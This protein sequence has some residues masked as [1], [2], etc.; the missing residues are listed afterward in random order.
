MTGK[1]HMALGVLTTLFITQ[2]ESP[3]EFLICL[4]VSSMGSVL[5]DIDVSTSSSRNVLNKTLLVIGISIAILFFA[6][7]KWGISLSEGIQSI[8]RVIIGLAFFLGICIYGM[9]TPH[10]SFMHSFLAI[11][12]ITIATYIVLPEGA[13]YMI[14]SMMSHIILDMF[15]KK[16]VQILYPSNKGISLNICK[17]NGMAN[18]VLFKVSSILLTLYVFL[19]LLRYYL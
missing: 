12:L 5:S 2:P 17:A 8:F 19:F 15:N 1:T 7:F 11:A 3:K 6:E 16:K 9:N 10:R 13:I 4:G 18:S 14:I